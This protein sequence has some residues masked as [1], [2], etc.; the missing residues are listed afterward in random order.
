MLID[1]YDDELLVD[2][3]LEAD[4]L[5]QLMTLFIVLADDD[6][7]LEVL[8]LVTDDCDAFD[9]DDEVDDEHIIDVTILETDVTDDEDDEIVLMD[10]QRL[11]VDDDEVD[12]GLS[13]NV[14]EDDEMDL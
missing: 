7:P 3:H 11:I 4:V 1:E 10:V 5:E 9:T 2:E 13:V 12:D 14:D 6:E 8:Q